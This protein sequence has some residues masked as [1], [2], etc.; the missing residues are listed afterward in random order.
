MGRFITTVS[1]VSNW[2]E[3]VPERE[4][5]TSEGKHTVKN[6]SQRN[7]QWESERGHR[8][9]YLSVLPLARSVSVSALRKNRLAFPCW[10]DGAYARKEAGKD[11]PCAACAP[12]SGQLPS[13]E[14]T[15]CEGGLSPKV[16]VRARKVVLRRETQES[17]ETTPR[18]PKEKLPDERDKAI[19]TLHPFLTHVQEH[20]PTV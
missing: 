10:W 18:K 13:Q 12:D 5:T 7:P 14:F 2:Q 16:V 6:G 19:R 1:Q 17:A 8:E 11:T 9:F 15:H 4:S 3:R 20:C